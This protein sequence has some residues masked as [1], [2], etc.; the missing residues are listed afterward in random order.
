M[1]YSQISNKFKN[2]FVKVIYSIMNMLFKRRKSNFSLRI[3]SAQS[4]S[5]LWEVLGSLYFNLIDVV[6]SVR[7]MWPQVRMPYS[8]SVACL[9]LP[10]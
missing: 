4:V 5:A 8:K 1:F 7:D 9:I 6:D 10:L 2:R 3:K